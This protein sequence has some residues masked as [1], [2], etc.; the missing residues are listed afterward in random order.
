MKQEAIDKYDWQKLELKLQNA[1]FDDVLYSLM[2]TW[3]DWE[4]TYKI[5]GISQQG[6]SLIDELRNPVFERFQDKIFN[7]GSSATQ[8]NVALLAKWL[9]IRGRDVGVEEAVNNLRD[10][11]LKS[12][13]N[14][15]RI[16]AL[17]ALRIETPINLDDSLSLCSECPKGLESHLTKLLFEARN[18]S[19]P[20]SFIVEDLD[21]PIEHNEK[22]ILDFLGT[23]KIFE[24][25]SLLSLLTQNNAPVPL[26]HW[27]LLD[28]STPFSSVIDG[29]K[30]WYPEMVLSD[31]FEEISNAQGHEFAN[32][33]RQYKLIDINKKKSIDIGL[34]RLM[35][36]I[37]TRNKTQKAIDL[38]IALECILTAPDTKDQLSLQFRTI[39]A[40]LTGNTLKERKQHYEIYKVIYN[41]RSQAVHN[42][43]LSQKEKIPG[44][45]NVSSYQII[46]EGIALAQKAFRAVINRGGLDKMDYIDL[47]LSPNLGKNEKS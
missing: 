46:N 16:T 28:P 39:G 37:N 35:S 17:P 1:L 3:G 40:L 29:H 41:L 6:W 18:M 5:F 8:V 15:Y 26:A 14:A 19:Y 23:E 45:G 38:G 33:I 10:Y 4:S 42:G 22:Y 34:Y 30:V 44:R 43:E 47:M 12:V 2:H 24:I 27:I 11:L 31:F 9:V 20:Y 21:L 13:N 25:C 7:L 36:A 32:L